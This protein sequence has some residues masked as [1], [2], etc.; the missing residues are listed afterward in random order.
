RRGGARPRGG[1]ELFARPDERRC[2]IVATPLLV[3]QPIDLP[4]EH[5]LRAGVLE[6]AAEPQTAGQRHRG[7]GEAA[8]AERAADL[9]E[10]GE[11]LVYG[12]AQ[13]GCQGIVGTMG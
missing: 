3:Q 4:E 12:L 1:G 9:I 11:E 8:V 7:G 5:G 10:P 6:A 13:L 2:E